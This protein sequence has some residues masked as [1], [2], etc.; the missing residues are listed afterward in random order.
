[1]H[2]GIRH[3][4]VRCLVLCAG[5]TH[6]LE[7]Y[8]PCEMAP[9]RFSSWC[10]LLCIF[11][12]LF[13]DGWTMHTVESSKS[14]YSIEATNFLFVNLIYVNDRHYIMSYVDLVLLLE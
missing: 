14:Q 13:L 6:Y 4:L 7:I 10:F 1:M 2:V 5:R 3:N 8:M 9:A 11:F 12:E